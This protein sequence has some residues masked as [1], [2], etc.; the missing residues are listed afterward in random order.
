MQTYVGRYNDQSQADR[1]QQIEKTT[2]TVG[3]MARQSQ[4]DK[5]RDIGW[6]RR[7]GDRGDIVSIQERQR[8]R[9][10]QQD[11]RHIENMPTGD[12][13]QSRVRQK[14]WKGR[15]V[16]RVLLAERRCRQRQGD[17]EDKKKD[18]R[19]RQNKA[20]GKLNR[21]VRQ[22]DVEIE[23]ERKKRQIQV[24]IDRQI[25][26]KQA[27]KPHRVRQRIIRQRHSVKRLARIDRGQAFCQLNREDKQI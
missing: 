10:K 12:V 2:Q 21:A 20:T 5:H 25:E 1:M 4:V 17:V 9:D 24:G 11:K 7:E 27:D 6:S 16:T 19:Y 26:E 23:R 8:E 22:T 3:G 14:Q 15:E 18:K 13:I